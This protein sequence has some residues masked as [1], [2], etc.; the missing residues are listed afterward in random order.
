MSIVT[1]NTASWIAKASIVFTAWHNP[2]ARILNID[3]LAVGLAALLPWSTSG[4]LIFAL[5][6]IVALIP[7]FDWRVFLRLL[8]QP[9]Y[10]T[11][12]AIFALAVLGTLWSVA[13]GEAKLDA[14]GSTTKLL[15]LPLLLY[16][17]QRTSRGIWILVA[18]LISS[19]S[20]MVASWIV[21]II[22]TLT[23]KWYMEPGVVVKNHIDQS[24]VF[25]LCAIGLAWPISILV[26][27]RRFVLATLLVVVALG[28]FANLI[29]INLSRTVLVTVP[30]IIAISFL[31]H[32]SWRTALGALGVLAI[33]GAISWSA[34]PVLRTKAMSLFPPYRLHEPAGEPTSIEIRYEYWRKSVEFIREAPLIGHGTG[35][36]PR[37]FEQAAA[38]Q[39]GA[40]AEVTGNPHSQTL[41]V[42]IQWGVIGVMALYAMWLVHLALFRR[43]G[44]ENWTGFL[45]VVQNIVSSL[46][47]SH[48]FDFAEG[49]IYVL[50]VGVLGGMR[51]GDRAGRQ[52]PPD[53][54]G[55]AK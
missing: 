26:R 3:L 19:T 42:A 14:L 40:A 34:S 36:I 35:S 28:F 44:W 4:V 23:L 18:F 1:S 39:S 50:G 45:I 52:H 46:F 13:P 17:F 8:Q 47:N 51:Q 22:P 5:L 37:L 30:V 31:H 9:I 6:W 2:V 54:K 38:H 20:L 43:A 10:F 21:S 16:H 53:V 55:P 25:A 32:L 12:I 11:P 29:F 15:I 48:L 49:W 27:A 33:L 7:T 24:H 41:S